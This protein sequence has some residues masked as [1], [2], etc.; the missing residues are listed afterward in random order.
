M[1]SVSE[2]FTS[3]QGEGRLTGAP[4]IFLRLAGC[5][6]RCRFCDTVYAQNVS[7]GVFLSVERI[8]EKVIQ[9]AQNPVFPPLSEMWKKEHSA[10][11]RLHA[12]PEPIEAEKITR[13][14]LTGGEP[15]LFPKI[16]PLVQCLR[17]VGFHVTIETSG[18]RASATGCDLISISP[19]TLNSGNSPVLTDVS[20][21]LPSLVSDARD[22]QIKFV[23]DHPEDLKEISEFLTRFPYLERKRVLLMPQGK[24]SDEILERERWVQRLAHE[25][26]F[27]Y[28]P[29]AH[30]FWFEA[31]R[32]V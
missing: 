17:Y 13:V 12:I 21:T 31:K 6:L 14:V 22:Y 24:T 16:V 8:V 19:K 30:L 32:G 23:V 3:W 29:R 15:L 2:I 27:G 10:N 25:N 4:S 26:G 11:A 9:S 7:D 20:Q 28:S 1:L 5:H 18:T